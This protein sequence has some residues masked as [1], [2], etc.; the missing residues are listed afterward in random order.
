MQQLRRAALVSIAYFTVGCGAGSVRREPAHLRVVVDSAQAE[1]WKAAVVASI[2]S[3]ALPSHVATAAQTKTVGTEDKNGN[4]GDEGKKKKTE[5]P[6]Q[7]QVPD[8]EMEQ[9]M[10]TLSTG[11]SGRFKQMLAGKGGDLHT[12]GTAKIEASEAGCTKLDGTVCA[13]HAHIITEK[14]QHSNGR[15]MESAMD[16]SGDSCLPRQC[17]AQKD[18]DQLAQF[19]HKQAKNVI[20]GQEH[21]VQLHVDCSKNGGTTAAVGMPTKSGSS[22]IVP[23]IAAFAVIL[24]LGPLRM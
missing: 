15:T 23:T 3:F 16:V 13:T 5:Q 20:P 18:L 12:F 7:V 14:E 21:E 6:V 8:S 17:M 10:S 22:S 2:S 19:M 4:K 1:P 24:A 9:F 11:C